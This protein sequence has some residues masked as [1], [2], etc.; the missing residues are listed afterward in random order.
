[1]ER[2]TNAIRGAIKN[3]NWFAGLF[4]AL[5]LPDI[6]GSLDYP[7]EQKTKKRYTD[8][9]NKNL[10]TKYSPMFSADDCFYF[11]CSCLHQGL[12]EHNKLAHEKIHFIP[13]L[14]NNNIVHMNKFNDILQMQ[15]DIFCNDIAKA[16][17]DWYRARTK[18]SPKIQTKIDNLIKVYPIES[19]K[20]FISF[21]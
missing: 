20:P 9:F 17:D 11:R 18:S 16:V 2:F 12:A 14:P 21:G 13:P 19:L 5:C 6:C 10:A 7:Y 8:W 1:M 4:L 15:I 3:K